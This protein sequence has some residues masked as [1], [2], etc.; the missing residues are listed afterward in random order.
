ML[1][2]HDAVEVLVGRASEGVEPKHHA[3]WARPAVKE[4]L[5]PGETA[6]LVAATR[7]LPEAE[8][9]D[10]RE[11]KLKVRGVDLDA[12]LWLALE[13]MEVAMGRHVVRLQGAFREFDVD[14]TGLS[15]EEF[16]RLA[17]HCAGD[18]PSAVSDRA[19]A[20]LFEHIAEEDAADGNDADRDHDID[21]PE[22]FA[23]GVIRSTCRLA[24][25]QYCRGYWDT[26]N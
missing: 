4:L 11:P 3:T 19:K 21:S 12:F 13:K 14:S 26:G 22:R 5:S 18:G 23:H 25:P 1:K 20:K 15:Y 8:G 24:C 16:S 7:A 17:D 9:R 2:P 10:V 6:E